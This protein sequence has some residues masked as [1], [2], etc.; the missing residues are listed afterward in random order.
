MVFWGA[1]AMNKRN[2]NR[3][4]DSLRKRYEEGD[5]RAALEA[6][7]KLGPYFTSDNLPEEPCR[8]DWDEGRNR[9]DP[10][11]KKQ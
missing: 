8:P 5:K 3:Y 10:T 4:L 6:I 7:L 11:L 2:D 1:S 9:S